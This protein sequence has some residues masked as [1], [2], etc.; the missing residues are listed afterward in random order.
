M[1][2]NLP[3]KATDEP[4]WFPLDQFSY[5]FPGRTVVVGFQAM[6]FPIVFFRLEENTTPPI[7]TIDT[8]G[9][10]KKTSSADLP[11]FPLSSEVYSFVTWESYSGKTLI[12][13]VRR[14]WCSF[15]YTKGFFLYVRLPAVRGHILAI[16]QPL[17]IRFRRLLHLTWPRKP[18]PT[19][20]RIH[21]RCPSFL[22]LLHRT[23]KEISTRVSRN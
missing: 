19:S 13:V 3:R 17:S 8:T 12:H 10:I 14:C 21:Q 11:A 1:V 15:A 16:R 7:S 20:F 18:T 5:S 6:N 4:R 23:P 9:I 2:L 22:L